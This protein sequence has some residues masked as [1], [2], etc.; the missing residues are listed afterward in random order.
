[1]AVA[2]TVK[3]KSKV[4][5]EVRVKCFYNKDGKNADELIKQ[6]FILFVKNEVAK[7][8]D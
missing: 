2:V 8:E 4:K 3:G 7:A 1:M 5:K 6:S